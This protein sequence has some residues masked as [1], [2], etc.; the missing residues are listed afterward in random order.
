[1][2]IKASQRFTN[3]ASLM[4]HWSSCRVLKEPVSLHIS[5]YSDAALLLGE[6]FLILN[7][8]QM[9]ITIAW[10]TSLQLSRRDRNSSR[11]DSIPVNDFVGS[12][13]HPNPIVADRGG[14]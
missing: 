5:N 4:T 6:R 2:K 13:I 10:M 8:D 14:S 7:R 9:A 1:M 12:K 11:Y 3:K